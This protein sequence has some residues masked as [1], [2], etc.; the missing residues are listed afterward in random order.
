MIRSFRDLQV[1]QKAMDTAMEVYALTKRFPP[2][3]KYSLTDQVR[4]SSRSVPANV[5][6][7]WRKRRYPAAFVAKLND[8]EGEAAETQT[9]L[10]I[11]LRCGYLDKETASRLDG[12]YNE[13][14]AMLDAM[15]A[16]PEQWTRK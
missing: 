15:A 6:E 9:H 10:E 7:A 8:A 5:A 11:A 16:N 3:E 4:R 13:I 2:E 14:L 1:W 12:I